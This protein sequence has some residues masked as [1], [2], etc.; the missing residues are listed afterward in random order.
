[1]TIATPS[2]YVECPFCSPPPE[3][4][5][6]QGQHVIALWDSFPV[7]PGHALLVP[8]RH[9]AT[10][11]DA[12]PL[13]KSALIESID[14]V[15]AMIEKQHAPDGYNIGINAGSAAG[16]TIY[17]LH[18]HLIPRYIG[19]VDDPR[20]GVR[21]VIPDKGNY[22]RNWVADAGARYHAKEP[23]LLITGGDDPLRPHLARYLG[24]ATNIDV[25]V[26]F[27]KPSGLHDL[28][29]D[30][31]EALERGANLRILTG[32]YLGITD[33]DALVKLLD[34]KERAGNLVNLRV[35][36]TTSA[37]LQLSRAFHPKAYIFH[38]R[39]GSGA[40]FV[41]SS[42]LSRSALTDGV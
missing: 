4:I 41:G 18:V 25:V 38:Q 15:K 22:L 1:M 28:W 8:R 40:A 6:F 21:N 31:T 7:S 23:Q 14:H 13:E 29:S 24:R 19:D 20:G 2:K 37:S 16:Q 26:A 9:V 30:L 5:I 27:I 36:N 17:H 3:R 34:L 33:P 10:W 32:D 39:D 35:F 42:N 12:S 11:F